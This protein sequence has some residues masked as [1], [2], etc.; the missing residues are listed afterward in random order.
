[1]RLMPSRDYYEV[2]GVKRT[3][4]ADEMKRA[5]RRLAKQYHP[6][7]NPGD[8]S[9]EG[10]FKEV[11]AAY[12]VLKDPQ[13]RAQYDR[14]GPAAVG[15]WQTSPNGQQVYAWSNDG[16]QINIDDLQDL[17][18]AFGGGGGGSASPFEEMFGGGRGGRGRQR[19]APARRGQDLERPVNLSFEQAVRGAKL[20]IDIIQHDG[21]RQTL[22][23][24]IPAGVTDGQR[25]RVRGKGHPGAGGGPAGDLYLAISVRAHRYF[26]RQ[27]K[28]LYIDVPLTIAEA[29]LGAKV[30]V[31]T[32]DGFVTVTVPA[33]TSSGSKLRLTGRGIKPARGEAGDLYVV[34]R[35][36]AVKTAD[37]RQAR[38]LEELAA[39]LHGNPRD[40]LDW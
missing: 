16:P 24:K 37:E 21:K 12:E 35:I 40:D 13:K 29:S 11:Q 15:D 6:D 22:T 25:I 36:A 20:E 23:V 17:F 39:T 28:D 19:Q 32:L 9:A 3:A 34:V 4:T 10:K 27:G 18:S 7:R 31:P 33:G 5:Y 1:L 38:L 2:L 14:F 30:D 26:R 8:K